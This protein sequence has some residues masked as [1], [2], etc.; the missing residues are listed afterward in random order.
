[1]RLQAPLSASLAIHGAVLAFVTVS[2]YVAT[3]PP[4]A[5]EVT[6]RQLM[7]HEE[8]RLTPLAT[9][10]SPQPLPNHGAS[11]TVFASA[12][13]MTTI[14]E[15]VA[16]PAA[17]SPTVATGDTGPAA[18][19]TEPPRFEAAYLDNPEPQYPPAA[20]RRGIEGRVLLEVRVD[21]QGHPASVQVADSSGEESLDR[22]AVE[23]VRSWRFV[24]ARNGGTP[25]DGRVRVPI[26]FRLHG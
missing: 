17:V 12:A 23:A 1:M 16:G 10:R 22:A 2:P 7:P 25:V 21:P 11:Q 24:P 6:I 20:R 19:Q 4:K 14:T 13:G 8:K 9:T 18:I 15:A 3:V 5:L 26:R